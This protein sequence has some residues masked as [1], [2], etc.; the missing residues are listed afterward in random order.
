MPKK[1]VAIRDACMQ[2]GGKEDACQ[3]KAA[4]IYNATRKPGQKPVTSKT[5]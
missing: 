4:R 2:K 1:Y 5:K 3:S